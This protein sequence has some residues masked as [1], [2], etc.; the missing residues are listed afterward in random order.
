MDE[1]FY[2]GFIVNTLKYIDNL[3][4]F[5][6]KLF[7]KILIKIINFCEKYDLNIKIIDNLLFLR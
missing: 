4:W 7:S 2:A 1:I 5:N 6:G 3:K